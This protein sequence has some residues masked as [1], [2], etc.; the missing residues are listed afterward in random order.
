M[1]AKLIGRVA[2]LGVLVPVRDLTPHPGQVLTLRLAIPLRLLQSTV[3]LQCSCSIRLA[4]LSLAALHL[5]QRN[6]LDK[7]LGLRLHRILV[8]IVRSSKHMNDRV[9]DLVVG[10]MPFDVLVAILERCDGQN[11]E[12]REDDESRRDGREFGEEL[13]DGDGEEEDVGYP[14]ELL[15]QVPRQERDDSVL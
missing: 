6:A 10:L 3:T 15:E 5:R 8:L 2:C 4:L 14:S 11:G 1:P 9:V 12:Q 7:G 13:Q